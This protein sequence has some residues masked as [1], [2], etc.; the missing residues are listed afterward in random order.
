M[1]K[2]YKTKSFIKKAKRLLNTTEKKSSF[3]KTILLM[4]QNPY[5]LNLRT[6]KVQSKKFGLMYS[7]RITDDLRIIWNF[8]E[9]NNLVLL[10]LDLGGHDGKNKVY[11]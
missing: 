11:K 10:L 3:E 1:Y 7:S 8:D 9:E 2:L 4:E 5:I 6:H